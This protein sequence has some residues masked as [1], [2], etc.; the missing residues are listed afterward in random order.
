MRAIL[1]PIAM[2]S[3][4]AA[5]DDAEVPDDGPIDSPPSVPGPDTQ[6]DAAAPPSGETAPGD[7]ANATIDTG[8]RATMPE[9]E[10]VTVVGLLTADGVECQALRTDDGTI[11]T[12]L[13]STESFGL[14]DRVRVTGDVAMVSFCMQGTSINL[15]GIEA[16]N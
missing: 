7:Q 5:C 9:P 11:Y 1:A 16:A 12:L 8:P 6:D 3:L 4:L 2:V 15:T 10:T 13:G 14:G